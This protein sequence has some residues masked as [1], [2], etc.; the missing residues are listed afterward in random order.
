VLCQIL[1]GANL[2][3]TF[4]NLNVHANVLCRIQTHEHGPKTAV[5]VPCADLQYTTAFDMLPRDYFDSKLYA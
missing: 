3:Y 2:I 5:D 4:A 1:C